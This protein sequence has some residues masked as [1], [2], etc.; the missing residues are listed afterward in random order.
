[1][2]G[3]IEENGNGGFTEMVMFFLNLNEIGNMRHR[4]TQNCT[5]FLI[6]RHD[7]VSENVSDLKVSYSKQV[8]VSDNKGSDSLLNKFLKRLLSLKKKICLK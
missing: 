7:I 5:S 2:L 8:T 3:Q 1:M 4:F 6:L